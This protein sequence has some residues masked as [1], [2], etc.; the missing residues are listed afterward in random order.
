VETGARYVDTFNLCLIMLFISSRAPPPRS[1]IL[2]V[3][4]LSLVPVHAPF[5]CPCPSGISTVYDTVVEHEATVSHEAAFNVAKGR[6]VSKANLLAM[7]QSN[8]KWLCD[9]VESFFVSYDIN[10]T[11][12]MSFACPTQ[13]GCAG[14]MFLNRCWADRIYLGSNRYFVKKRRTFSTVNRQLIY[15]LSTVHIVFWT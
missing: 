11:P 8:N 13:V 7:N 14:N 6:G 10:S 5:P 15:C 12:F 1:A 9:I 2:H 3:E 4:S